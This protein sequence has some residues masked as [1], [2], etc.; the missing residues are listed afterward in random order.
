MLLRFHAAL[1]AVL[2]IIGA[3]AP[4][5]FSREAADPE[6]D[7]IALEVKNHRGTV[8][9]WQFTPL[10]GGVWEEVVREPDDPTAIP[11]RRYHALEADASRYGA[12]L[13]IIEKLP[14]DAPSYENCEMLVPDSSYGTLRLTR[15]VT[16]TEIGW[17]ARCIDSDYVSFL[18]I[19]R[20]ANE[21][22]AAWGKAVPTTR[23]EEE[24]GYR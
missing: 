20:S 3:N 8:T 6:W 19:L 9:R 15:G 7:M 17:Q 12:L 4:Q 11:M 21:L 2:L 10:Y 1:I 23:E 13:E 24:R 18:N 22:V 5:A 14:N 16:T